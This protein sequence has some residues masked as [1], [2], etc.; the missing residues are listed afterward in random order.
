MIYSTYDPNTGQILSTIFDSTSD[1]IPLNA[2][3]GIYNDQ[4]HYFDL[5]TKSIQTKGSAPGNNYTWNFV[6]KSWILDQSQAS[7][8]ARWKRDQLLSFVDRVNP[9]WYESL[10]NDQKQQLQFYR[11]E[12][13][14]VPQQLGFPTDIL[15]PTKPTWL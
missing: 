15:W 9:I 3:T 11:I 7:R 14:N 8:D 1:I 2:I 5:D 6:S 12:L 13:L 4:D 10:T